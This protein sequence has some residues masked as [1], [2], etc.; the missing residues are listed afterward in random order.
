V[1]ARGR[2]VPDGRALRVALGALIA[3]VL[4][5]FASIAWAAAPG[6]AWATADQLLTVVLAVWVLALLPWRPVWAE[7]LM[8]LFGLAAAV[9]LGGAL[10]S[11]LRAEELTRLFIEDRWASPIGY[12][13]GLGNFGLFAALPLIAISAHPG[14][15]VLMKAGTLGVATLLAGCAL[16]PES[17]GSIVALFLAVPVLIALSPLRWRV[18]ARVV[19]MG[20]LL[21]FVVGPPIDHMTNVAAASDVVSGA[22]EDAARAIAGAACLAALAGLFLALAEARVSL[23]ERG[24]RLA[25]LSGIAAVAAILLAAGGTAVVKAD[26][27]QREAERQKAAWDKPQELYAIT[28]AER[29]RSRLLSANPLQRYE[30]WHIS[31][32]A[33]AERPVGGLGAGGFE[34]RYTKVRA[35][36]KYANFPHSLFMRVLAETGI[37]GV[38][39]VLVFVGAVLAGL[40]A[41]L[42]GASTGER[43]VVA[44]ALSS[45]V[46]FTVHAQLDWLEEFPALAG[47]ALGFLVVAMVVRRGGETAPPSPLAARRGLAGGVVIGLAALASVG[48]PYLAVRY[49]ERAQVVWRSDR[50]A[51]Y[52]DLDRAASMDP[53][54]DGAYLV[55]GT[56]ALQTRDFSRA[57]RAFEDALAREEGWLAHFELALIEAA[58]GDQRAAMRQLSQAGV[59]NPLEPAITAAHE[60]ILTGEGVDPIRLNKRLFESPL[61]KARRLT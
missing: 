17:R 59:L 22:V 48:A 37:L 24:T 31:L 61:F 42:R 10:V 6:T 11:G 33:F 35:Y 13:N 14:R 51:A 32:D 58:E 52:R 55:E 34:A 20:A 44:G 39:A 27:I 43:T 36:D 9:V 29:N 46:L 41:R 53:L 49:K 50:A 2:L 7:V 8:G 26:R 4:V 54:D 23:G 40:L 60:E 15:P 47:P 1:I 16:L 19:V 28:D 38:L 21:V 45:A 3:A 5:A 12:P 56:I 57:R 25:R 18:T 30:Y